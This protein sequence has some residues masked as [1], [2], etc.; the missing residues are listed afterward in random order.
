M[1]GEELNSLPGSSSVHQLG[2]SDLLVALRVLAQRQ[3]TVV[4]LGVQ[5]ATTDW[6]TEL[7]PDVAAA[8][9][10][11]VEAAVRELCQKGQAAPAA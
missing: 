11:L 5:P 7:S 9:N 10:S 4:L 2:V 6:N 3:P 1:S 8:M